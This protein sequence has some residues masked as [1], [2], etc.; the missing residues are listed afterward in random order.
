MLL[1]NIKLIIIL[2]G[3]C[4]II[5]YIFVPLIAWVIGSIFAK[6]FHKDE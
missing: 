5:C 3:T 1:E 4:F 6:L 2:L